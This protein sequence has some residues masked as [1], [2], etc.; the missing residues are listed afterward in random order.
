MAPEQKSDISIRHS[1]RWIPSSSPSSSSDTPPP[2]EPTSTMVLTSPSGRFVDLRIFKED[3]SSPNHTS[4]FINPNSHTGSEPDA[5]EAKTLPLS[6]MDW[7]IAGTSTHTSTRPTI[8]VLHT[9]AGGGP[10]PDEAAA[11]EGDMYRIPGEGN[12]KLALEKGRMVNPESG[13]EEE[14]EEVWVPDE[15]GATEPLYVNCVVWELDDKL[16]NKKGRVV[17]VGRW[18]QGISRRGNELL[19]ER[20]KWAGGE[21]KESVWRL[22][23]RVKGYV[24]G[25]E[26]RK[27]DEKDGSYLDEPLVFPEALIPEMISVGEPGKTKEVG[28]TVKESKGDVWTLVE[29]CP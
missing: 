25:E 6:R 14:Y 22:E 5:E 18:A 10:S 23:A 13:Q 27:V 29:W 28:D 20:W 3:P 15:E 26:K 19:C 24:G 8:G 1:I 17:K 21:N 12:E 2:S 11:D 9:E 4:V 16:K 7:A